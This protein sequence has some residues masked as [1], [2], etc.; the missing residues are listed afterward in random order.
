MDLA[1]WTHAGDF[2]YAETGTVAGAAR[3]D[4][5]FLGRQRYRLLTTRTTLLR[6][7]DGT[8]GGPWAVEDQED[9]EFRA[10]AWEFETV[11][12]R[13][14]GRRLRH[15]ERALGKIREGTYG[16]C[17]A[18]GENISGDR[19]DL[20]PETIFAARIRRSVGIL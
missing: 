6:E 5:A 13:R 11:L 8:D 18:T 10:L 4:A 3:F 17:D 19:L 1:E 12:R 16:V 20:V 9:A 14:L 2:A 7:L 15:V